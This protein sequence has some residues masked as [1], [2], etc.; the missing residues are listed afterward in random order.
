MTKGYSVEVLQSYVELTKAERVRLKTTDNAVR[1][2]EATKNGEVIISPVNW[3]IL[4]VHNEKANGDK[5]YQQYIIM[6]KSGATYLTGS[7]NFFNTFMDIFE[8]MDGEDYQVKAIRMPSKN[9]KGKDFLS[10][11]LV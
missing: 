7:E 6:D 11:A 9:F 5:D 8:E 3:A 2:D 1:L 10:C 4:Q